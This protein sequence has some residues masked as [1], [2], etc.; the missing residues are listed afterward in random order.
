MTRNA[1][2]IAFADLSAVL[3]A[4][5]VMMLAMSDFEAPALERIATVFGADEGTWVGERSEAVPVP[6][7]R[8]GGDDGAPQRDYLAAVLSGRLAQADWPWASARSPRGWR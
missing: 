3:C 8:R 2:L 4:F 6:S 7:L 1:W 5:F